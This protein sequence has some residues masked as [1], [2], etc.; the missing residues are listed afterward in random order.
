M[1]K[2]KNFSSNL[3][4]LFKV[5]LTIIIILLIVSCSSLNKIKNETDLVFK[6]SFDIYVEKVMDTFNINFG[7]G[8]AVVKDDKMVY[9]NYKGYAN[10]EDKIL[11][12]PETEFYIAS[13]TKSFT[14]L[15]ALILHEKKLINM[16][17]SL[18]SY[19]PEA[20][21]KPEL[22]A[23]SVTI[24]DLLYHTSGLRNRNITGVKSYFGNYTLSSLTNKLINNTT[25]NSVGYGN[26]SYDNLGYNIFGIIV[27]RELGKSWKQIVNEEVLNP[28]GMKRT[29]GNMSDIEKNNWTGTEPYSQ[30]DL[31]GNLKNLKF[32]KE[33]DIMHAAGGLITTPRDMSK[34]LE[35]QLNDG[36][37]DNKQIFRKGLL[38]FT[39]KKQAAQNRKFFSSKRFGYGYG[40]NL[41]TNSSNDTL[42][43]HYGDFTG[44]HAKISFIP[45][46]KT[47]VAV[48][49]NE[50]HAGLLASY[51]LESYA[52]DYYAGVENLEEKYDE[53]LKEYH[54]LLVNAFKG[55]KKD[56]ENRAKRT[57]N[58]DLPLKAYAG[59]YKNS[60]VDNNLK[61]EYRKGK[62]F[63][64]N[65]GHL[66][67]NNPAEPFVNKNSIRLELVP[68]N[69][70]VMNFRLENNE[71]ISVK[72]N[73]LL[74]K[75]VTK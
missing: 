43:H 10:Y 22:K 41:T 27:E 69:G 2:I 52:F 11:V 1:N 40:W 23:D 31:D 65:F 18:A 17:R 60:S 6:K 7:I 9:E 39:H 8:I 25:T 35:I 46:H 70:S 64:A 5:F 48:F 62:G 34:W 72:F 36:V 16:D 68:N 63:F 29:S 13:S 14:A 53:A 66:K 50:G 42:V 44:A 67:T 71:V 15:A 45:K 20:K 59:T 3:I 32:K 24:R 28:L 56:L 54:T 37:L 38:P 30:T 73:G 49:V 26:F 61:I 4:S 58:L 21:F 51:L 33:D 75:K 74:F 55:K 19:F 57:W 12:T 47:G